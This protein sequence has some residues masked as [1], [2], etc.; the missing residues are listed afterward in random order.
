MLKMRYMLTR[1]LPDRMMVI[2][3]GWLLC[4]H[5]N[6]NRQEESSPSCHLIRHHNIIAVREAWK[7]FAYY[8]KSPPIQI[9]PFIP[10]TTT[11]FLSSIAF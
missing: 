4:R 5:S 9:L 8:N 11:F 3:A 2:I 10:C 6:G 7:S 1:S